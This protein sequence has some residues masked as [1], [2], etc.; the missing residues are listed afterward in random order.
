MTVA[1]A[2]ELYAVASG[3]PKLAILSQ[4]CKTFLDKHNLK[5]REYPAIP[6]RDY[7]HLQS[8]LFIAWGD[9]P[10]KDCYG[11]RVGLVTAPLGLVQLVDDIQSGLEMGRKIVDTA[12]MTNPVKV[13]Y[14]VKQMAKEA[15]VSE[16]TSPVCVCGCKLMVDSS[17]VVT[18]F[19]LLC[20]LYT[21]NKNEM[22]KAEKQE[23]LEY[24]RGRYQYHDII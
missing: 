2:K 12:D 15:A 7:Y 22:S 5:L 23:V 21:R 10:G 16:C 13:T 20:E 1:L 4:L 19:C 3:N 8:P 24:V 14:S 11:Y 18:K 9:K 17:A 6:T